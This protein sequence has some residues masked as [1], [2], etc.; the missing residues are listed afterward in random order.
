MPDEVAK[1]YKDD[2]NVLGDNNPHMND[3]LSVIAD[4]KIAAI[5]L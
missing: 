2:V 5:L 3:N 1:N 4:H